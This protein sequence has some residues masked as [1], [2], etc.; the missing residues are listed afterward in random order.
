MKTKERGNH[1]YNNKRKKPKPLHPFDDDDPP[2]YPCEAHNNSNICQGICPVYDITR[3]QDDD[4]TTRL[5]KKE[6]VWF[7]IFL[8]VNIIV[9]VSLIV[10]FIYGQY[11]HELPD[12]IEGDNNNKTINTAFLK[13]FELVSLPA[14]FLFTLLYFVKFFHIF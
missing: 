14:Y 7:T 4:T 1:W 11:H 8:L 2:K 13:K 9:N 5:A 3:K 12:T 6:A 10:I